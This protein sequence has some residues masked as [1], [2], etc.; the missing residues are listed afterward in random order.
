M[1]PVPDY[2]KPLER[3]TRPFPRNA[4]EEAIARREEA[5]PHLL[6]ALHWAADR[7]AEVKRDV[8]IHL[9]ALYL[10]AQFRD[11]RAL[12]PAL[13]IARYSQV[14][15]LLGDT[16]AEGLGPLLASLAGRDPRPI[17][18]LIEDEAADEFARGSGVI[19]LG[20]MTLAGKMTREELSAYLGKLF[21]GGLLREASHVWDEL[22][23]VCADF[24]LVEHREKIET[25]YDEDLADWFYESPESVED[26]INATHDNPFE[27]EKYALIED[28]IAEMSGWMCF[29]ETS[30]LDTPIEDL[31]TDPLPRPIEDYDPAPY[32]RPRPKV[33]RNDPCPCGSGK[34]F[35]KCCGA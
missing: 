22:I 16:V 28:T 13:R 2:L 31:V 4:V 14:D 11:E 18:T 6:E 17:Q 20:A 25:C 23:S 8:M 5:V 10:L 1:V 7:P 27:L 35:K 33:G 34:K 26:R 15:N 19:A 24:R 9:F 21:D 3:V 29:A 32:V 12:G 30:I